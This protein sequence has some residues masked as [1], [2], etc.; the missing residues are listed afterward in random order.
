MKVIKIKNRKIG[1]AFKPLIIAEIGINHGGNVKKA[2]KMIDDAKK[3][4]CECVKFQYHIPD[5]EMVKI[6]KFQ[7][8]LIDQY[9]TLLTRY[10]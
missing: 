10:I 5:K 4:G 7:V 8:I 3:A 9:G 1:D 2:F 6:M